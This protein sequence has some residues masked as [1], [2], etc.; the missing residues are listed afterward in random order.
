MGVSKIWGLA[1]AMSFSVAVFGQ[2]NLVWYFGTDG[3]G[4]TFD[5]SSSDPVSNIGPSPD[6]EIIEAISTVSDCE[7]QTLFYSDGLKIHDASHRQMPNGGGLLGSQETTLAD[8]GSSLNGV[9]IVSDPG[10]ES[11]YYVFTVGEITTSDN[12][13]WRY[14]IVDLSLPGNGTVADPL[15]DVVSGQKN[16]LVKG[17]LVAE[18]MA[19][20]GNECGDSLWVVTH[21][22][23]QDSLLALPITAA[24]GIGTIVATELGP[25]FNGGRDEKRGS[26]DFSPDGAKLAMAFMS[27]IGGHIFDFDFSTG[28]FTNH[29]EVPGVTNG[30]HGVEFSFDSRKVYFGRGP[31]LDIKHYN[32][33]LNV[34]TDAG[35]AGAY[36]GDLERAPNGKIYF[37]KRGGGDI[38]YLG[39]IDNPDAVDGPS[40]GFNNRGLNIGSPV[41]LGL[42]QMYLK[43][44]NKLITAEIGVPF[45]L[46][47]VCDKG[48]VL[49]LTA[50]PPCGAWEGGAYIDG[51]GSFDPSGLLT[52]G[53]YEVRYNRGVCYIN[54]TIDFTVEDCCPPL[55]VRDSTLCEGADA[56]H[57]GALVDTGIGEW[58]LTS[59]PSGTGSPATFSDSI[60]DPSNYSEGSTFVT[61]GNYEM[62]YTYW[63]APLPECPDS[64]VA[65]IVVDSFPRD[66]FSGANSALIQEC[67]T[68]Y[69]FSAKAGLEYNWAA[70]LSVTTNPVTVSA[71]GTYSLTVNS[72]SEN[73]FTTDDIE[74]E[75]D[76]FPTAGIDVSDTIVCGAGEIK[77]GVNQSGLDYTWT[78]GGIPDGDSLLITAA[79]TYGV[80]I[81]SGPDGFCPTLDEVIVELAPPFN[82]I[83]IGIGADTTL[84][85]VLDSLVIRTADVENAIFNWSMGDD[86]E[87]ADSSRLIFGFN[88]G[89]VIA[90]QITDEF[91]CSGDTSV[92]LK[93]FCEINDPIIPNVIIPDGTTN[94]TFIP[95]SFPPGTEG[96]YDALYPISNLTVYDRWGLKM[97]EDDNYPDWKGQNMQGN[98]VSAGVYYWTLKLEDVNG[99][100]RLLNGFVQ[101]IR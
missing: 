23:T 15:G 89:D 47:T 86:F 64:A 49:D 74:I 90:L 50:I 58:S 78:G 77:I 1:L 16:I 11:R 12:N 99:K 36:T 82:V 62:T 20:T 93:S 57:M 54:D 42:P 4:L 81:K 7:G 10:S 43:P 22:F 60:F 67:G 94:T 71:D 76:Q 24:S 61:D 51:N 92:A 17:G 2:Q 79:G 73:C 95:I 44:G 6:Y 29:V 53:V 59:F 80:E 68:E 66:I 75:F 40:S 85:P 39:V 97:Y 70:P 33:D 18:G 46:T 56:F 100:A 84:C 101:V 34:T 31:F 48:G 87:G 41:D 25:G 45:D 98:P 13:G 63:N 3:S 30:A 9:V 35:N 8:G 65:I 27:P 55:T 83:F 19:V 91:G 5:G 21:S 96:V 28:V 69:T 88:D 38:N 26:M 14:S 32:I 37:G 52:P 72:P